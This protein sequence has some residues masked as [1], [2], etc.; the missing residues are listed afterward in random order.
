MSQAHI[1]AGSV[2]SSRP[3]L[4]SN[5]APAAASQQAADTRPACVD[6][7]ELLRGQKAVDISHNGLTYR[8][9]AT[10]LG[11]LILTK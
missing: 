8:L 7:T 11:K 5:L 3:A 6:S 2:N 9:Q 4:V 10:R 1:P